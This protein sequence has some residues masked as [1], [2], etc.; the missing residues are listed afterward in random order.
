MLDLFFSVFRI[1]AP[2]WTSAFL[3][4]RRLTVYNRAYEATK[5]EFPQEVADEDE[6]PH[7]LNL[8]DNYIAFLLAVFIE[9]GLLEVGNRSRKSC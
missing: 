7:R 8:V 4:G 2:S 9:A 1:K 3:D 5:G 6:M